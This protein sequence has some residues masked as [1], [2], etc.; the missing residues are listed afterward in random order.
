MSERELRLQQRHWEAMRRHVEA[1][2]PEEAC[3]LLAGED[4]RVRRVFPV[5]NVL[6]SPFRFRMEPLE[7]LKAFQRIEAEGMALL[8]IYH[9]HPQGPA[10]PSSTDLLEHAYPDV[11]QLIWWREE[12]RWS[13]QAFCLESGNPQ[14][15]SMTIAPSA[16]PGWSDEKVPPSQAKGD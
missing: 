8:A 11:A 7:Q 2:A 6:H 15:I 12:E 3:G 5:E 13:C 10:G 9:S 16:S 14:P 1:C 4:G